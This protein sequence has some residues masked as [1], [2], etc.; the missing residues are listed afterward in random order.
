MKLSRVLLACVLAI[1]I[2]IAVVA[3]VRQRTEPTPADQRVAATVNGVE[4]PESRVQSYIERFRARSANLKSQEG[5]EAWLAESGYTEQSY[6]LHVIDSLVQDELIRQAAKDCGIKIDPK[7]ID[8]QIEATKANYDNDENWQRVLAAAGYT[9]TEYRS[10]VELTALSRELKETQVVKPRASSDQ[11]QAYFNAHASQYE[12][13][14]SSCILYNRADEE[15]ARETLATLQQSQNLS[16]DFAAAAQE[17]SADVST[18]K[19][20]GDMGWDCLTTLPVE[21]QNPLDK[22][23]VGELC[24]EP[25]QTDFG[26]YLILCTS[27]FTSVK[28]AGDVVV[29]A[30]PPEISTV[31]MN[32]LD[33]ELYTQAFDAYLLDLR[34]QADVVIYNSD[35]TVVAPAAD[36]AGNGT[37]PAA[38]AGAASATPATGSGAAANSGA[39]AAA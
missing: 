24:S 39:P 37:A 3:C 36:A 12:G 2:G 7:E 31:L 20:G 17:Q 35:G 8:T 10:A 15:M 1:A 11:V 5:W 18:A 26:Y 6:R 27:E 29:E 19:N 34:A 4:I 23:K 16:V 13:K 21:Y 32:S 28:D 38:G 22:L 30:V 14:R 25:V 33:T 9:E